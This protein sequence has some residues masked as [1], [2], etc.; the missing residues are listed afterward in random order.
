[1]NKDVTLPPTL[2]VGCLKYPTLLAW[3][4]EEELAVLSEECKDCRNMIYQLEN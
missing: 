1:M 2:C 4:K 3:Y